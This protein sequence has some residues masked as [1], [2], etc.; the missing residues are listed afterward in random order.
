[1]ID[2]NM[3]VRQS[4]QKPAVYLCPGCQDEND[5]KNVGI[6]YDE[7]G[8]NIST[9]CPTCKKQINLRTKDKPFLLDR[10]QNIPN[11]KA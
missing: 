8:S 11:F 7:D 3:R 6:E 1:M 4:Q 2:E 10:L 9:E 5:F